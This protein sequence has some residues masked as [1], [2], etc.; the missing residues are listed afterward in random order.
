ME[1]VVGVG[2]V[3]AKEV[4]EI[5]VKSRKIYQNIIFR[6]FWGLLGYPFYDLVLEILYYLLSA[7][8]I[9]GTEAEVDITDFKGK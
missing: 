2:L 5:Y 9:Q 8:V 6:G 3:E 1:A 7:V 4:I